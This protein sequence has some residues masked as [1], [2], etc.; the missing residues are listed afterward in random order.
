MRAG[1]ACIC[2]GQEGLRCQ[3]STVLRNATPDRLRALIDQN[4]EGLEQILRFNEQRELRLFRLGNE[5]IPFASHPVNTIAW[6]EEFGPSF[7]R[8]GRWVR[9]HGHRLSFHAS[10]YTILNSQNPAVV[11]TAIADLTYYGRVLDAMALG[12]EHKIILH[13]GAAGPTLE[14]AESR[15]EGALTRVPD[16]I[17]RRLV[18]ENDDRLFTVEQVL[19]LSARTGLPVVLDV[20]HHA[21]LPGSWGSMPLPE[22]LQ[23]VFATWPPETGPPKLHFSSQDPEKRPGAHAYGVD[24]GELRNFLRQSAAVPRDFD[25]MFEA[26]G[27]DLAVEAVLPLLRSDPRFGRASSRPSHADLALT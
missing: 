11:Q 19:G 9:E 17:R 22:L 20:L 15:F 1:Y 25:L 18:I 27:K 12:L 16:A 26:K 3:R 7:E 23:R 5:F 13:V 14:E 6:W 2:L 4:L 8:I 21:C 24:P 10:H